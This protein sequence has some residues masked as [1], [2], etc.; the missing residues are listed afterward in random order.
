V[1]AGEP[2]HQ[3]CYLSD[4][5]RALGDRFLPCCSRSKTPLLVLDL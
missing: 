4:A 3:D 5:E 2:D 1:L